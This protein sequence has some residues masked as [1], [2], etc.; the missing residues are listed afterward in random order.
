MITVYDDV[1]IRA[2]ADIMSKNEIS[3]LIITDQDKV[4]VGIVTDRDLREKVV[5]RGRDV[6]DKIKDIMSVSLIKSDARDYCFE[7]LLKMIRYNIHH[8]LVVD[9]GKLKGIVT[10][11]DLMMLQGTS[12][13]SIAREIESKQTIEGLVPAS[14][15]IN[16]MISLLLQEGA[17]AS[18][19]TRIITEVNDILL[20]KILQIAE[21]KLGYPPVPYC[22]IVFGSEG[23]KE[24]TFK[25]DQD[26]AL[27]YEDAYTKEE[28]NVSSKY[29]AE[30]GDI[31]EQCPDAMRLS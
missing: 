31:C 16:G 25:T 14:N 17:K 20:K 22:W 1:S 9:E 27:I 13:I 30:I 8:L 6:S 24:Q 15:K 18:N 12:P 2:A 7:A 10:N 5:A 19:I 3:S 29:F 4:P 23:R 11:H 21:K 26:N 28:Q